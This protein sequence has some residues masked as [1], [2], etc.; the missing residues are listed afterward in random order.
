MGL[1]THVDYMTKCQAFAAAAEELF[2]ITPLVGSPRNRVKLKGMQR[3]QNER[4]STVR[5]A[6][7]GYAP[8]GPVLAA[9]EKRCRVPPGSLANL[10]WL[11]FG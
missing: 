2:A 10:R 5:Q 1:T 3:A 9:T 4:T 6:K 11:I 7:N 8:I